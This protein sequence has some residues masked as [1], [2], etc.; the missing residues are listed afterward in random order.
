VIVKEGRKGTRKQ[1]TV[2]DFVSCPITLR[3]GLVGVKPE[4]F[5]FWLFEVLNMRRGDEFHDLF[6]GSG[7]VSRAWKAYREQAKLPLA[8]SPAPGGPPA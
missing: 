1:P 4:R 5:C 8:F 2:P 6:P 7:A 3:K